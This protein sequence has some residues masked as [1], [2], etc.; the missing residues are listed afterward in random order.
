MGEN[1]ILIHNFRLEFITSGSQ[2]GRKVEQLTIKPREQMQ[3]HM[4]EQQQMHAHVCLAHSLLLIRTGL[5]MTGVA[6]T[7]TECSPLN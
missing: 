5:A 3:Q 7:Q 6:H 4:C 2:S 1:I